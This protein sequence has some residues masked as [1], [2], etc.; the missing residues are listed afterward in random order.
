MKLKM[1]LL[2][3]LSL[4]LYFSYLLFSNISNLSSFVTTHIVKKELLVYEEFMTGLKKISGDKLLL[5]KL[6][7]QSF[8]K[9][10][11]TASN[12][13]IFNYIIAMHNYEK[14]LYAIDPKFVLFVEYPE[15]FLTHET[16]DRY[17][18]LLAIPEYAAVSKS[19]AAVISLGRDQSGTFKLSAADYA[20]GVHLLEG[21]IRELIASYGENEVRLAFKDP[22]N[23]TLD[24]KIGAQIIISFYEKMIELKMDDAS[25][26]IRGMLPH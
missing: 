25:L 21:I 7:R 1:V 18:L 15:K 17:K 19:E 23:I 16:H 12:E 6:L 10:A 2:A 22:S 11:P 3:V 4:A 9:Y 24:P 8:F 5:T 26:V 20:R 13:T 14:K